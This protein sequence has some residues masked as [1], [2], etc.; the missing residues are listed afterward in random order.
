M[1]F[2]LQTIGLIVCIGGVAVLVLGA[3]LVR[4]LFGARTPRN[5]T[6]EDQRIWTEQGRE[7]PRHD[8]DQI[9][10]SG[11][12]GNAPS[13][14]RRNPGEPRQTPGTSRGSGASGFGTGRS[15]TN[16]PPPRPRDRRSSNDQDDDIRSGGGFG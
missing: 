14:S 10:S 15:T 4:S 1:D 12:F 9:R 13:A 11:G 8:S 3:L 5:T 16:P 7:R 6:R 2:N